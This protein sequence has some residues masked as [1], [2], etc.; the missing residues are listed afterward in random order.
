MSRTTSHFSFESEVRCKREF[1]RADSRILSHQ[2]H[3]FHFPVGHVVEIFEE[4]MVAGDLRD[5]LVSEV[6]FRGRVLAVIGLQ[7]ADEVGRKIM[8]ETGRLRLM[9]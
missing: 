1:A 7:Q 3:A 8:P 5:P 9:R 6:V 2:E 4:R